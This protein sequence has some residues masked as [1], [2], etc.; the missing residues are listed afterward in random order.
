MAMV[1]NRRVAVLTKN[2]WKANE[3]TEKMLQRDDVGW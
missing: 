1:K 2:V 3:W